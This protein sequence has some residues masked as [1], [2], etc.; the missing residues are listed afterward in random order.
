MKLYVGIWAILIIATIAEAIM[1]IISGPHLTLVTIIIV[2]ASAKAIIIA[3]YYQHLRND[4]IHLAA[5]P[6]SAIVALAVLAVTAIIS[7]GIGMGM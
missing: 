4:G 3:L 7:L 5:L 2:I 6:L 1:S